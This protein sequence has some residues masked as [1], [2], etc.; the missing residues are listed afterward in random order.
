MKVPCLHC[1]IHCYPYDNFTRYIHVDGMY[2]CWHL[3]NT[4]EPVKL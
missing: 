4:A 1:G 2:W 3:R